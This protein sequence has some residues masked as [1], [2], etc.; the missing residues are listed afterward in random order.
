[1]T[2]EGG[3]DAEPF[4]SGV[5]GVNQ[6]RKPETRGSVRVK[7][8]ID[9]GPAVRHRKPTLGRGLGFFEPTSLKAVGG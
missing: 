7:Q 4:L 2:Q 5:V 6:P 9:K 1:M 3:G 8:L